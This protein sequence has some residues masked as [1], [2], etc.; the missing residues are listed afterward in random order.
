MSHAR[1]AAF[2][3]LVLGCPNREAGDPGLRPLCNGAAEEGC[4]CD[5]EGATVGCG[6]D[7]GMCVTGLRKCIDGHWGGCAGGVGPDADEGCDGIDNDCDGS[8]DEGCSCSDGAT[9]PCGTD[10]GACTAGT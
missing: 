7:L 6:S 9:L 8:A 10:E 1:W 3:L 4:A 2:A 5:Q